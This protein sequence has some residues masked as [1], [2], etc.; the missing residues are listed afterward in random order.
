[1]GA[2]TA[3]ICDS[4]EPG[5]M[6]TWDKPDG[7]ILTKL[8]RNPV[9]PGA[10]QSGVASRARP[11]ILSRS[12]AEKMAAKLPPSEWAMR[13]GLVSPDCRDRTATA[14]PRPSSTYSAKPQ[15][16]SR[17]DA[18][19]HSSKCTRRPRRR[20]YRTALRVGARSQI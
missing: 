11:R 16:P 7:D 10:K 14:S 19:V 17:L 4:S 5:D 1:M 3:L 13:K 9:V 20:Q 18:G 12:K 15:L 6:V 2:A 8:S